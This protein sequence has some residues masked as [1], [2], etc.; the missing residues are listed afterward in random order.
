MKLSELAMR[1][2]ALH[3]AVEA[4]GIGLWA[5]AAT[6][7]EAYDAAPLEDPRAPAAYAE[8][9]KSNDLLF[10][11]LSRKTDVQFTDDDPYG[12]AEE[13]AADVVKNQRLKIF[14]GGSEHPILTPEQNVIFR[15][16]H[17]YY[18]HTGPNRKNVAKP[19]DFK[20]FAFHLRGEIN[21]YLVHAKIAPKIAVPVMFSEVVAQACYFNVCGEFPVQ[22]AVILDGFDHIRIGRMSSE[23]QARYNDIMR[24]LADREKRD[25]D[26][27]IKAHP[28]IPKERID[29]ALLSASTQAKP[30]DL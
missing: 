8:L 10:K 18:A 26:L 29:Q 28:K 6:V 21:A 13:V 30:V 22:K 24:Q 4:H 19:G 27:K 1:R 7:A 11:R 2:H 20:S 5:Y 14:T 9:A 16:V 12:S 17:D 25:V 23:H 15:T 3:E